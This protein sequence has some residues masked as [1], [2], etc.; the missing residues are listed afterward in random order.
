MWRY[1]EK[2]WRAYLPYISNTWILLGVVAKQ[3]AQK[4]SNKNM[5]HGELSGG[6]NNQSV[7]VFQIGRYI[8]SEWSHNGKLRIYDFDSASNFFGAQWLDKQKI[9]QNFILEQVHHSPST[10]SWQNKVSE[11]LRK[12]CDIIKTKDDWGLET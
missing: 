11:W 5:G 3:E 9:I 4:L 8:F 6:E 10:Y 12:N 2:F 7:F 1:R